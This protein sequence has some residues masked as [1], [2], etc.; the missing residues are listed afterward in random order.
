MEQNNILYLTSDESVLFDNNYRY[1]ISTIEVAHVIKKGTKIT[2][3]TNMDK[4]CKE[5]LFDKT[6]LIRIIGKK[7]S[8]KS[9]VDKFN[10]FYLQGDFSTNQIKQV[11]YDFITHYLL[12]VVC[13]KPEVRIKHKNNKIKQ[14]CNACG[15]N[16]YLEHV[17]H[18]VLNI[19]SKE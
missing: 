15:N 8:C 18:I 6:M 19:L 1:K 5:L 9:G 12:C 7:L 14:K 13:D 3:I 17:D 16:S 4:F 10:T 2:Q 11:V